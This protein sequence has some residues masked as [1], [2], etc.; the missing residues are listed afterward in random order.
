MK[1]SI[2]LTYLFSRDLALWIER[3]SMNVPSS[4][5]F[6][7]TVDVKIRWARSP[8]SVIPDSLWMKMA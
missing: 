5:A 1:F 8:V 6:V 7:L 4:L 3:I 2:F